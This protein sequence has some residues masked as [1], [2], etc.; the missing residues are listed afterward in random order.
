MLDKEW[1]EYTN[2]EKIV[3]LSHWFKSNCDIPYTMG[4]YY[5]FIDFIQNNTDKIM[6]WLIDTFNSDMISYLKATYDGDVVCS[7]EVRNSQ[8][9]IATS[10]LLYIM[11]N[12]L[13][14]IMLDTLPSEKDYK[15]DE[16]LNY[17][18]S[19][20]AIVNNLVESYNISTSKGS[21]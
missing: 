18:V 16:L 14:N 11:R 20:Q 2:D 8:N 21:R 19:R 17:R 5:E 3:I 13:L 9:A 4:E 12:N 10:K 15:G 6:D 7:S 1:N